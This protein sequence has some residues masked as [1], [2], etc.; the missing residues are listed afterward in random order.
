[1]TAIARYIAAASFAKTGTEAAS[2]STETRAAQACPQCNYSNNY[3]G[4]QVCLNRQK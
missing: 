4:D 3:Y 1:M 2:A